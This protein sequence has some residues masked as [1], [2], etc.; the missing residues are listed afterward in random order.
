MDVWGCCWGCFR[1]GYDSMRRRDTEVIDAGRASISYQRARE[2]SLITIVARVMIHCSVI[3][4]DIIYLNSL[5][6]SYYSE[7]SSFKSA[8]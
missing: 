4:N 1:R 6:C 8:S 7:T 3:F 2:G 5:P